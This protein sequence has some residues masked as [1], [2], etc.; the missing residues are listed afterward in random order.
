MRWIDN[1]IPTLLNRNKNFANNGQKLR[2]N[3]Y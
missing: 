3:R 2:K 1:P